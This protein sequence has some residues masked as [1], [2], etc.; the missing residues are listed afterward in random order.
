MQD[1]GDESVA[2]GRYLNYEICKV[3]LRC[4]FSKVHLRMADNEYG[5]DSKPL[6]TSDLLMDLTSVHKQECIFC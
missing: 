3:Y 4:I 2:K 1:G 5:S 6:C